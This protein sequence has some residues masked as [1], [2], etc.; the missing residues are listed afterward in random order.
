LNFL[1]A[2][3]RDRLGRPHIENNHERETAMKRTDVMSAIACPEERELMDYAIGKISGD[4]A[5]QIDSHLECCPICTNALVAMQEPSDTLISSLRQPREPDP[6]AGEAKLREVLAIVQ[7]IGRDPSFA[8]SPGSAAEP[9]EDLGTIRD[10]QLLAKLGRGGMGTVYKALHTKLGK[11]VALKVLPSERMEDP[12][13]VARFEQEMRAVGRLEHAN[14]VGAHDAGEHEGTHFL[15]ME[16]VD[17]ADLSELVRGLGP[18][19]IAEACE[20][21]RHAAVGLQHAHEHKLVHR[22]IKPSN[23]MLTAT[24]R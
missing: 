22:D 18:L 9:Q 11:V 3:G 5:E 19:P 10:Y 21:V 2:L 23:L 17:G 8:Q 24:G 20:L 6:Y 15:V 12:H 7:A 4:R 13:A 1:E 16:Y 14:I